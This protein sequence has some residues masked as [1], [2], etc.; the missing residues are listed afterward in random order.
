MGLNGV[1]PP[2]VPAAAKELILDTVD[3]ATA[4]G[5]AHRWATSLW[6]VS[7]DRVHRWRTRSRQRGSLVDHRPG[8]GAVHSLLTDEVDEIL[9]LAERWGPVDRSHRKLAHRGSYEHRVWVSPS[10]FRRVLAAHGLIVPQAPTRRREPKRPWPAW[11]VWQ[12]NRIWIWDV[13][14]FSR[15]RRCVF[16]IVD[17]VNRR[18]ITT[19]V[20]AE[21]SSSQV[22]VVFDQA[23]QVEG[24]VELLTDERLDLALDD[25]SRPIL[26]A[27]SDNGPPM[28]STDTRAFMA[29]V[30]IAQHH[31][32]PSTPTDQA[33]IESFFGHIKTEWPHLCDIAEANLLKTELRRIRSEY[34]NVRLHEAVGYVT[35]NDEHYHQGQAIRD[36]RRQGLQQARQ[37]RLNHNRRTHLNNPEKTK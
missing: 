19:L 3:D 24:L 25:P 37:T 1:I 21:E 28:V 6:G 11:L 14:H 30:A 2:R 4:A 35:P 20:S 5:L 26:L 12:P 18:W 32:R 22:V 36:A 16:A 17:M 7:D 9:A 8:G 31:G 13:T 27:V 23:L 10:T 29:A 15:A 34:N 33:W